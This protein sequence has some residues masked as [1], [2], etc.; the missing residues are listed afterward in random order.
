MTI[1][2]LMKN[3]YSKPMK[4]LFISKFSI[5]KKSENLYRAIFSPPGY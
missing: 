1:T 5:Y 2:S 3:P 4:A